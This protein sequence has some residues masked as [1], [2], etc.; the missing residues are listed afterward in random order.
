MALPAGFVSLLIADQRRA[1]QWRL[2]LA[3]A[4]FEARVVDTAGIDREKGDC[5]VC[6]AGEDAS[7]ARTFMSEV[8]RGDATLPHVSKLSPM[9][10][11]ALVGV[12]ITVVIAAM[13][14]LLS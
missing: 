9:A 2:G 6:V 4:G 3:R 14:A 10:V 11:R 7:G 5:H 12:V 1:E 8:M 13:I